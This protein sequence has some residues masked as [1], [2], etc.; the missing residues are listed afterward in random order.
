[1]SWTEAQWGVIARSADG[2]EVTGNK[3][4][5]CSRGGLVA[6][7]HAYRDE[8]HP[9]LHENPVNN[10]MYH[11]NHLADCGSNDGERSIPAIRVGDIGTHNA[12]VDHNHISYTEGFE[13]GVPTQIVDVR[14]ATNRQDN[15]FV[16]P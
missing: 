7:N 13:G 3:I 14:G 16:V 9:Y 10:V 6:F 2:I 1:M 15:N 11:H 8:K 5:N 12:L 4:S